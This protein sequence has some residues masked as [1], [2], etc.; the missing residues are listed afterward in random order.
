MEG[1]AGTVTRTEGTTAAVTVD[2]DLSTQPMLPTGHEGYVFARAA[3]GLPA[4]ILPEEASL[5]PPTGLSATPGDRQATPDLDPVGG[6]F[7]A[8]RPAPV[9]LPGGDQ[10]LREHWKDHPRQRAERG[11][12]VAG[13]RC[14][15]S[16]NASGVQRSSFAR[17]DGGHRPE[18][19]GG[20]DRGHSDRA[21]PES[22]RVKVVSSSGPGRRHLRR[23]TMRSDIEVTFDQPMCRSTGNPAVPVL[24]LGGSNRQA[25]YA[26]EQRRH[27]GSAVRL[28]A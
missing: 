23:G 25:A 19:P 16:T 17:S 5:E 10:G 15:G 20:G 13:T 1:T 3:S 7:R 14:R 4:E 24:D 2:V 21:R 12:R 27:H 22:S 6:G 11:Q 9:P 8:S 28:R 26:L 18:R